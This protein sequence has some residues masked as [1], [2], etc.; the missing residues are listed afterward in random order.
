MISHI[1]I[2]DFAIIEEIEIDLSG[3]FSAITGETGSGKS[4][5]IEA[6]STA[7]GA[8]ADKTMVRAGKDKAVIQIVIDE[9]DLPP[10][11]RTGAEILTRE[12]MA[13]GKSVCRIN[14]EI[15]TLAQLAGSTSRI[16]DIHGQYEHQSLLDPINH[17]K[18]VDA[19]RIKEIGPLKEQVELAYRKWADVKA[20]I[21]ELLASEAA[22]MRERDF[23]SYELKE[24]DAAGI[25][26][27]EYVE[28]K[29][30]VRL[31][32]NSEL[33]FD[34]LSEASEALE[35]GS[36]GVIDGISRS[37]GA[38]RRIEG[39]SEEY[40]GLVETISECFY[41]IDDAAGRVRELLQQ[42]D[43]SEQAIN[44]AISR[45]DLL[46]RLI[47]KYGDESSGTTPPE[48]LS[49]Y[50]PDDPIRNVA[51]H[52]EFAAEKLSNIEHSDELKA[53][54]T[55]KLDEYEAELISVSD[56]LSKL[57]KETAS[58]LEDRITEELTDLNF[59]DAEFR[60]SFDHIDFSIDGTDSVAFM[61]SANKG[62]P[63]LPVARVASGGESSR[64]M[65]ALKSVIGAFDDIPTMVFDEIDSGISGITA[66][67][68][69][70]KLRAMGYGRQIISITHLPQIATAA[71]HHYR[72]IKSSTDDNTF[73][74]VVRI[75]GE[76]RV[77]EIAR[78]LGGKNVTD[79]TRSSARELIYASGSSSLADSS[80]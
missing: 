7:L 15:V 27:G 24:I 20:K 52:R 40:A 69:G 75:T 58:D 76:E 65:L 25:M 71:D 26:P 47:T 66:S 23:L 61:I 9:S 10:G 59:S 28:L 64:I 21:K 19:Y 1:L 57:R 55:G 78:L 38:L 60:V 79:V 74:T 77:E 2:K 73:T 80:S 14:G 8:R 49:E 17:L 68:V 3:G 16:A 22:S 12:I 67:V 13:T 63:L 30:S 56:S 36:A 34:T 6:I 32:Q 46:D 31:M 41:S 54:L 48:L 39:I 4:I 62:Q 33:I 35:G 72:I 53:E 18:I 11:Q 44:N 37:M 45:L 51:A 50:L 5:I 29:T 70:E 43:Y 42:T